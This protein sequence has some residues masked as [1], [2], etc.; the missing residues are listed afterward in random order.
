MSEMQTGRGAAGAAYAVRVSGRLPAR[1]ASWFDG[2]TLAAEADGT[3]VL[4]GR[5]VDQAAL[6]GVLQALRDLG[7]PLLSVA[8]L[9]DDQDLAGPSAPLDLTTTRPEDMT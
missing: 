4:R 2:F 1:W 6:H 3:T 5:V 7:L 8:S 9:P